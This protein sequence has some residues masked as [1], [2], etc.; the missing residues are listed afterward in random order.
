VF[1]FD[2]TA[3]LLN[4][5]IYNGISSKKH[6]MK[7]T[8]CSVN[9]KAGEYERIFRGKHLCKNCYPKFLK[10]MLKNDSE[11][12]IERKKL[13]DPEFRNLLSASL[14]NLKLV[15][16]LYRKEFNPKL[17]DILISRKDNDGFFFERICVFLEKED[18]TD[19][20]YDVRKIM[21]TTYDLLN[22]RQ[23]LDNKGFSDYKVEIKKQMNDELYIIFDLVLKLFN[24]TLVL[25][26]SYTRSFAD[27]TFAMRDYIIK[28]INEYNLS[29]SPANIV[30]LLRKIT[31][32]LYEL[33]YFI[34]ALY[35]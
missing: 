28:K 19:M 32:N 25:F 26:D 3:L 24:N 14:K 15:Y 17:A 31:S 9:V 29:Y 11:K 21:S 33:L 7:C 20:I 13:K 23:N 34:D 6:V 27:E 1:I 18:A 12:S 22:I 8:R 16:S 30:S 35:H 10:H 4:R 5:K 2:L